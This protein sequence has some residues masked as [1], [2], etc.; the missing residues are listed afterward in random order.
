MLP[1]DVWV[2]AAP[3][4]AGRA[5]RHPGSEKSTPQ[6]GGAGCQAV[7]ESLDGLTIAVAGGKL[8]EIA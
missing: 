2:G 6:R 3:E 4:R 1:E 7:G 5:E 8:V